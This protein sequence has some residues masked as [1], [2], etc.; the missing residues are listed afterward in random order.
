MRRVFTAL[1][2][3]FIGSI[4]GYIYS[5]QYRKDKIELV[6]DLDNTLIHARRRSIDNNV[7]NIRPCDLVIVTDNTIYDLWKRPFASGFLNFMARITHLHLFTTTNA[8]YTTRIL[9]YTRWRRHFISV[10]TYDDLSES[11]RKADC[12]DLSWITSYPA[13]LI[14]DK[15]RNR[16]KGQPFYHIPQYKCFM[17]HDY[18]LVKAAATI[19]MLYLYNDL[20]GLTGS[21]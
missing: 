21:T 11:Q 7:S 14:D 3:S 19:V 10:T 2:T 20:A 16:C 4:V 17:Q 15:A 18:E 1:S 8:D 12:K 6:C 5:L 9:R 13:L